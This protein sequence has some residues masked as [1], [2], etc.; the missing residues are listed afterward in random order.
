MRLIYE[1]LKIVVERASAMAVGAILEH[2]EE[3][4]GKRVGVILTGGNIDLN[5]FKF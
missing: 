2:K 5:D 1:R 4:K 3:F